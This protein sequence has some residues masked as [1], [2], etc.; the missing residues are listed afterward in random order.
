MEVLAVRAANFGVGHDETTRIVANPVLLEQTET[1]CFFVGGVMRLAAM[2]LLLGSTTLLAGCGPST[3][4]LREKTISTLNTAA[5]AWDGGPDFKTD[6]TDAYGNPIVAT[7]SKRLLNRVL[8]VRS[9]GPD[10][11]PKNTDDITVT[12]QKA[13]GETTVNQELETGSESIGRGGARGII[14]G[15]REGL[16]GDGK[17]KDKA[18]K[19]E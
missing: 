16:K 10:G 18:A 19:K 15:I 7:V 17:A 12:R 13:H 4:E 1:H 8:E 11:L 2:L 5:D 6:A 3:R 14:E 9:Y